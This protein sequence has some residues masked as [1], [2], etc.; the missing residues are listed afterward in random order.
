MANTY[1]LIQATTVGSGGQS[2][3]SFNSIPQTYTD[4]KLVYSLRTSVA[5]NT[6]AIALTINGSTSNLSGKFMFF[7]GFTGGTFNASSAVSGQEGGFINGNTST[8]GAFSNVELY[9]PEYTSSTTPKTFTVDSTQEKAAT[10][11]NSMYMGLFG[12]MWNPGTQAGITSIVLTP[13]ASLLQHSTA[14]LY[15]ISKS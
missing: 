8:T 11:T 15:G 10:G 1:T 7:N 2:S 3:I 12:N 4:L 13:G 6:D 9:F 5:G 14:Y